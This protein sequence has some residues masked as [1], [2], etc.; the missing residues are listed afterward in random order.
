M[1]CDLNQL[2]AELCFTHSEWRITEFSLW[3]CTKNEVESA[4]HKQMHVGGEFWWA[5]WAF[6][7]TPEDT[8]AAKGVI[9]SLLATGQVHLTAAPFQPGK[10]SPG[11][12][13]GKC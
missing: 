12:Q 4:C 7:V 9:C 1:H 13:D 6:P 5:D 3:C 8:W 10:F 11:H 2:N